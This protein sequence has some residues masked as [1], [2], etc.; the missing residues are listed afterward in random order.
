MSLK[1]YHITDFGHLL[2]NKS[3]NK[4]KKLLR[5]SPIRCLNYKQMGWYLTLILLTWKIWWAP[6]NARKWQMGF[7]LAF[8][9]LKYNGLQWVLVQNILLFHRQWYQ[10]WSLTDLNVLSSRPNAAFQR[11]S[12]EYSHFL[13]GCTGIEVPRKEWRPSITVSCV[14]SFSPG[15]YDDVAPD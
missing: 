14:S 1:R 4:M 15:R 8:K 11:V 9:S 6:N 12:G 13:F 10:Y 5:T 7:M 3:S 2:Y